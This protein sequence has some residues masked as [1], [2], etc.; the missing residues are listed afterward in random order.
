MADSREKGWARR[1]VRVLDRLGDV[2][3]VLSS[4]AAWLLAAIILYDVFLRALLAPTLWADEV[5]VYLMIALSFLGVG[6]TYGVDGHFRVS[7]V[8]DLFPARGRLVLDIIALVISLLFS[9]GFIYGS[10]K[11]MVFSWSLNL[12]TPTILHLPLWLLQAFLP[13]GG[14][15]LTLAILRDGLRIY[16]GGSAVRDAK[17]TSEVI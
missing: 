6:A 15:L 2:G 13:I 12:Q 16:L 5:S 11:L 4:M 7:F 3:A 8:R 10:V 1:G 9:L 17:G 14:I